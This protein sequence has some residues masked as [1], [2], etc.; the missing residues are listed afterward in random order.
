LRSVAPGWTFW[1]VESMNRRTRPRRGQGSCRL[2]AA[3]LDGAG[4]NAVGAK[5]LANALR[6]AVGRSGY[7]ATKL[8]KNSGI[9]LPA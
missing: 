2:P 5:K 4:D 9:G 3:L 1:A 6:T 8:P 7:G